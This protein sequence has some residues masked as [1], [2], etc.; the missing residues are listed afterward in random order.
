MDGFVTAYSKTTGT[1]HR[2]P[3]DWLDHPVLGAGFRK[4]PR[5][6]E[7]QPYPDGPPNTNW[8]GAQLQAYADAHD[9][10]LAGATVK[11]DMVAAIGAATPQNADGTP[12]SDET[13]A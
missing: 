9:I 6:P 10:D 8:K 11:A 7:G 13:P 1:P 3:A 2:I 5:Q 12:L 4:T